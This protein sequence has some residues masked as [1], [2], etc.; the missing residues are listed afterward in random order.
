MYRYLNEL[1]VLVM[2]VTFINGNLKDYLT[3]KLILLKRLIIIL[4]RILSFDH[5]IMQ[6]VVNIYIFYEV[7]K[8][9]SINNYPILENCLFGAVSLTK[10]ADVNKLN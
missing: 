4:L 6:K 9:I 2:S 5:F 7:S 3:K 8:N 10:N 1:L